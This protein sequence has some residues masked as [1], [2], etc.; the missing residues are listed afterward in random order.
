MALKR[1]RHP[2]LT[3]G[4]WYA[5]YQHLQQLIAAGL[6]L[7]NALQ[8]LALHAVTRSMRELCWYLAEGV[9]R[10]LS[11]TEAARLSQLFAPLDLSL[12]EVGEVSG[13]M[14]TILTLLAQHHQRQQQWRTDLKKALSYPLTLLLMSAAVLSLMLTWVVPQFTRLFGS[15]NTALPWLTRMVMQ[16][17]QEATWVAGS[18]IGLF[19]IVL[20]LGRILWER[21]RDWVESVLMRVPVIGALWQLTVWLRV[22]QALGLMLN[23]GLP[24]LQALPLSAAAADSALCTD[25]LFIVSR[26]VERGI[27]L[28]QAFAQASFFP[29]IFVLL[30][31]LGENTGRLDTILL[32]QAEG[33]EQQLLN[34]LAI[35]NRRLEPCLMVIIGTMIALIVIAMY[36][37][38]FELGKLF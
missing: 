9:L 4:Q 17:A 36:L 28:H 23:A 1:Q 29:P 11:F 38:I 20:V 30:I 3:V 8:L 19:I 14:A 21:R 5:F 16:V 31:A 34:A 15:M 22:S 6:P 12:L 7:A 10:G 37:P 35:L 32:Q 13:R 24:L 33:F 26:T 27:A 18:V 2:S 25:A